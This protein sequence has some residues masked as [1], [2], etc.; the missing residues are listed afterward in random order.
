MWKK[1]NGVRKLKLAP[2]RGPLE[3]VIVLTVDGKLWK[4]E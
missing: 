1:I 2:V 4:W 3:K